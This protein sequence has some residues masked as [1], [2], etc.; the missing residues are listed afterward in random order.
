[1]RRVKRTKDISNPRSCAHF[2]SDASDWIF[3]V[4][5]GIQAVSFGFWFCCW[6]DGRTACMV[7]DTLG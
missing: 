4:S 6:I 1:M 3:V 2:E 7:N 5:W